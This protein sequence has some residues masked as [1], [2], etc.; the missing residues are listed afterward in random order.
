MVSM[1]E[2]T[3]AE[4]LQKAGYVT[5]QFG[6]WHLGAGPQITDHGFKHVYAQNSAGPFAA[7]MTLD[8]KDREMSN[9]RAEMYHVDG[10]SKAAASMIERYKDRPFFCTSPIAPRTCRLMQRRNISI[11]FPVRCP[12]GGDKHSP[13]SRRW[14]MA[15]G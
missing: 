12:S 15:S 13:C 1:P 9:V 5:A 11:V 6:K 14:M 4:R 3:I 10:C 7:N 2:L 8:G